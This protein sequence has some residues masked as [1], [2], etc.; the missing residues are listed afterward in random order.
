MSRRIIAMRDLTR[1]F[2]CL[3]Q[4]EVGLKITVCQALLKYVREPLQTVQ[5]GIR[6]GLPQAAMRA[7]FDQ[8]AHAFHLIQI[9]LRAMAA[10]D[11]VQTI[12]E[13]RRTHPARCTET[14]T[15]MGEE[16]DRKSTRLNSSHLVISYAV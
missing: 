5:D 11:L 2:K 1:F 4:I 7:A 14:A 9:I 12:F 3:V 13:Q 16:I 6:R 10:G 15:F 8:C